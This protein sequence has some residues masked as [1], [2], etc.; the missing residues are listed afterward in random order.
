MKK[1]LFLALAGSTCLA[2]VAPAQ[3]VVYTDNFN[4]AALN[5]GTSAYTV[6]AS[7]GDGGASINAAQG[8][9][10][11]NDATAATNA[12]GRVSVA[13]ATTAFPGFS[14]TLNANAAGSQV[15]WTFNL[16][17]GRTANTPSGFA[18]ANYSNAF[19]LGATGA[20]FSAAGTSG[21]ALLFGNTGSPDTFRLVSFTNGLTSD[22]TAAGATGNPFIVGTGAFAVTTQAASNDYYSFQ[23]AYSVSDSTWTLRGRDD[24][25][26]GFA[27]PSTGAFTTVG[28]AANTDATGA[29]LNYLG[30]F[31]NYSTAANQTTQFDNFSVAVVPE[32]STYALLCLAGAGLF[33]AVR[34]RTVRG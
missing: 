19:V 22:I 23:I 10:L 34:R 33:L 15:V 17:F 11:T 24:G 28:T 3:T 30:A 2:A 12:A 21:Y 14:P 25:A 20:D 18:A 6:T 7:A 4:R 5:G 9:E 16:R 26:T 27:D 32:P 13:T 31:W 1:T 8:L 29:A